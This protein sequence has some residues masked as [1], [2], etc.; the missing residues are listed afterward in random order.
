MSEKTPGEDA[1]LDEIMKAS[2]GYNVRGRLAIVLR[3][4]RANLLSQPKSGQEALCG[5]AAGIRGQQT[6][7]KETSMKPY[8]SHAGVQ[9]IH[10]D[11]REVLP[12]LEG[13]YCL[14]TDPPYGLRESRGNSDTG[15]THGD[16][17]NMAPAGKYLISDWDDTP[18]DDNCINYVRSHARFAII[19][20]GNYFS[21]PPQRGC[22]ALT[23]PS[24]R[25]R[26]A[27][28]LTEKDVAEAY[29]SAPNWHSVASSLNCRL[30]LREREREPKPSS[31]TSC[32]TVK[33]IETEWM[34]V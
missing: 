1:W 16:R 28:L 11:C 7:Y 3:A 10:G 34:D 18:P 32:N 15:G 29:Q 33:R 12:W 8:Y 19:W 25:I 20:G 22:A 27:Q 24:N 14:V 5:T 26:S 23:R 21:L 30:V 6:G 17:T 2:V 31:R 4:Y 13:V 9:I